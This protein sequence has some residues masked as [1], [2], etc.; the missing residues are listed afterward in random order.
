MM[1][2][3]ADA[4]EQSFDALA[5]DDAS[6]SLREELDLLKARVAEG[7]IAGAR[8]ALDGIKSAEASDFVDPYVE[9]TAELSF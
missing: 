5:E 3:K 9:T 1:E 4:L 8:P 6:I 7:L 2:L